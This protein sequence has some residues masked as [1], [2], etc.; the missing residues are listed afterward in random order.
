MQAV[1]GSAVDSSW[2]IRRNVIAK[3]TGGIWVA[4]NVEIGSNTIIENRVPSEEFLK[5]FYKSQAITGVGI[6]VNVPGGAEPPSFGIAARPPTDADRQALALPS[7]RRSR[8]SPC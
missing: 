5:V 7:R 2:K 4:G 1:G 6:L 8:R 3:N